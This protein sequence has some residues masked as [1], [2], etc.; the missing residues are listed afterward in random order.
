MDL[1][2]ALF[3]WKGLAA[4]CGVCLLAGTFAGHKVEAW[5]QGVKYSA[6]VATN[7]KG[8]QDYSDR[9]YRAE[10]AQREEGERRQDEKDTIQNEARDRIA[11]IQA[12]AVRAAGERDRLRGQLAAF[13]AS[14]RSAG[15]D[16][17]AGA[18]G[19]PAADSLDL[20]AIMFSESD[21]TAGILASALDRSR[22]AGLT[23]ERQYESLKH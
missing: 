11:V 12:D 15:A 2:K 8:M 13:T 9:A 19:P 3:G 17:A 16:P 7:A 21:D 22:D 20:L 6:L 23:C 10:T 1:V 14:H 18:G 4:A 5:R